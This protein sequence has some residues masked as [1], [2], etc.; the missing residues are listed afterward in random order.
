MAVPSP[1]RLPD[2]FVEALSRTFGRLGPFAREVL[3]YP[4]V[5]STN[6]VAAARAERGAPEGVVVV[7][8]AQ[9]AGRGRQGRT[10]VSPPGAGLYASALLR[11][12]PLTP[13]LT[14]AAGV[15]IAEG[16]QAAT[17]LKVDLKWPNDALVGG[18]KLAGVLAEAAT[19]VGGPYV[20]VGFGINLLP[21]AYPPDVAARAT[22]LEEELG[23]AVD[24]GL[25]LAECLASFA[26]RYQDLA[27]G[28]T[29]A[30]V[31]AWRSWA[32]ATFGR[33]VRWDDAGAL[34]EGAIEG[35]DDSGALMVRTAEGSLR[36]TAGDV[37][38]V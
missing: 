23:R 2:E 6:D 31:A 29:G 7:S 17:G 22:S 21:A 18:R 10:W 38:W 11:P 36:I 28:R 24:R 32:S 26:G 30:V 4:E 19:A 27:S 12:P 8:N 25:L 16:V 33:R 20:I 3:W 34:R 1:Q 15:A 5:S 37:A 13:L 9:S 35:L 14:I